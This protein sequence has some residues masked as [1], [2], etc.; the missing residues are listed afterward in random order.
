VALDNLVDLIIRCVEHPAA[1]NEI[2]L[3]SD[4]EDLSTTDLL[5]RMATALNKP[6]R[7]IPVPAS[8]LNIIATMLG[9]Q[10]VATR[11]LGS[12]QVDI[13]KTKRV[14]DWEPP[15]SVDDA[16]KKTANYFLKNNQ[17]RK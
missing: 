2:F 1:A 10:D 7:L 12:L 16:L 14:L 13:E 15:V 3:V 4:N 17:S 9:K 8:V 11:L 5:K 6:A